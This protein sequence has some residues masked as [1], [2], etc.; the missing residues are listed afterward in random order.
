MG[1]GI[2]AAGE[3]GNVILYVDGLRIEAMWM[4]KANMSNFNGEGD[5]RHA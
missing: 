2:L 4:L 1:V 3:V 5:E